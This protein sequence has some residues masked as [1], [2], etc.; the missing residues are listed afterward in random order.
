[1]AGRACCWFTNAGQG[2]PLRVVTSEQVPG[3]REG[4]NHAFIWEES[5]SGRGSGRYKGPGVGVS[6]GSCGN[7]R[8]ASVS[9]AS[10]GDEDRRRE[11]WLL[12][13]IS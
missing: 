2:R 12:R 1:M 7:G 8:G 10:G 5:V 4:P 11:S 3:G 13:G 9:G 6:L